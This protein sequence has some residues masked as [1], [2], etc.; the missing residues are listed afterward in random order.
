[1]PLIEVSG[2]IKS[3]LESMKKTEGYKSFDAV[4]RDLLHQ[5]NSVKI[6]M[7]GS[8]IKFKGESKDENIDFDLVVDHVIDR[9]NHIAVFFN[10]DWGLIHY[11]MEIHSQ[12]ERSR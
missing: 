6:I 3:I 12:K 7:V 9:G 11:M 8:K 4:V 2:K 1:M 5:A 10:P